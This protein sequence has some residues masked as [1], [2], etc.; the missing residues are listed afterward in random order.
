VAAHLAQT[1]R[2]DDA[3]RGVFWPDIDHHHMEAA[4]I[5]W[6]LFPNTLILPGVTFALC[7]RARPNGFNPDS[8]IFEVYAL[9]RYPQNQEPKTQWEY[10]PDPD[11]ERWPLVLKQD[12]QNMPEVQRGMK[13]RGFM[14]AR[15][16]PKQEVPVIHF[17]RVLAEY[18]G[19]AGALQPFK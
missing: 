18:M 8:C 9:E 13:S 10:I 12:F 15:P 2:R 17:H 6:H 1:A 3:A 5:D 4:G 14:G 16:D 19:G 7:Y 11:D